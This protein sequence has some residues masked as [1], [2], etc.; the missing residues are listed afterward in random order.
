MRWTVF[1][2]L[3]L[4][5]LAAQPSAAQDATH[6][7]SVDP[8]ISR[9]IER[10]IARSPTFHDLVS[11]INASDSYVYVKKGDCGPGIQACF[12]AVSDAGSERFLWVKVNSRK[13]DDGLVSLIGHEL[14][15]TLEVIEQPAVR[16]NGAVYFL[17]GRIGTHSTVG[18]IETRAAVEAG[19]KIREELR[20]YERRASR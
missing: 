8:V 17:Y 2:L 12:I 11:A 15:H 4:T 9:L 6:V 16:S 20:A 14:R 3:V 13:I 1:G 5:T 10:G 7:R 18:T 19:W